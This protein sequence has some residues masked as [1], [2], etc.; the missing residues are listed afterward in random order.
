MSYCQNLGFL[1]H[2]IPN[3]IKKIITD[4]CNIE[5]KYGDVRKRDE[6]ARTW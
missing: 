5:M 1:L 3:P 2:L 4:N 6:H